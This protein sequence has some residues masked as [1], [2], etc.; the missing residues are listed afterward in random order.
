[1]SEAKFTK[2]PWVSHGSGVSTEA[3]GLKPDRTHGYGCG[4]TFVCCLNDGE[5]HEY[6]DKKEQE[7]NAHLIAAAPELYEALDGLILVMDTT[8]MSKLF[9]ADYAKAKSALAKARG[10]S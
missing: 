7:A 6:T 10:E 2:G 1:M 9:R 5:Y 4:P 3:F 8:E